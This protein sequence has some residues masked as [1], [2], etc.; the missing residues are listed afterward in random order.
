M[1]DDEAIKPREPRDAAAYGWVGLAAWS[2]VG[3]ALEAAHGWK[4]SAYLDNALTRLLLT[5]AHAHGAMLSLVLIAFGVHGAAQLDTG[6]TWPRRALLSAWLL[7]PVGFALGAIAHPESDPSLGILL[8]PIGAL[9]LI[10][11]LVRVAIAAW[12]RTT[13]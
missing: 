2:C 4:A 10:A 7:M 5:L 9:L 3:L 6:E 12:K 11:A 1:S 8:V 13:P